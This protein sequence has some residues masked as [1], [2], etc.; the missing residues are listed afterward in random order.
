VVNDDG[1]G[2]IMVKTL[3]DLAL[4]NKHK[5]LKQSNIWKV[6]SPKQKHL[7]APNAQLKQTQ[8]AKMK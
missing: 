1:S 4:V 8:G 7:F 5:Q 6:K 2:N 3:T